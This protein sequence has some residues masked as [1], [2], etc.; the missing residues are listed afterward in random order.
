MSLVNAGVMERDLGRLAQAKTHL[1]QAVQIAHSVTD[2]ALEAEALD[3]LGYCLVLSGDPRSG[4]D[5]LTQGLELVGARGSGT[6]EGS[7]RWRLGLALDRMG[8]TEEADEH[9]A[10]AIRAHE[11]LG[12][13]AAAEAVRQAQAARPGT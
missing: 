10:A 2:H 7:L 13:T 8:R 5:V 12:E 11:R 3:E 6:G 9:W 4:Y 1:Q